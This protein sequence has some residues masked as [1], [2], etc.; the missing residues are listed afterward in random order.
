[1]NIIRT[2]YA[3]LECSWTWFVQRDTCIVLV[4]EKKICSTDNFSAKKFP[5]ECICGCRC[6]LAYSLER[7]SV[8][9]VERRPV[10]CLLQKLRV[11]NEQ[12]NNIKNNNI[13]THL[14]SSLPPLISYVYQRFDIKICSYLL[15]NH[16]KYIQH[17]ARHNIL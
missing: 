2:L 9:S 10:A 4:E 14:T 1:M 11:D 12:N 8:N 5:F 6:H 13:H 16:N 3:Q 17:Q 15:Q 7:S